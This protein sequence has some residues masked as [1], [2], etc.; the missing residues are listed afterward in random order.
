LDGTGLNQSYK[1]I[2]KEERKEERREER[3]KGR[4]GRWIKRRKGGWMWMN[5]TCLCA[6]RRQSKSMYPT[7]I[8]LTMKRGNR[9]KGCIN[10]RQCILTC[11]R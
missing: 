3:N 1:I 5:G 8:K 4:K 11:V 7:I 10:G 6:G 9:R 2:R